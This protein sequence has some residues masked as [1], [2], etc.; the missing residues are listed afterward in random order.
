MQMWVQK[1]TDK[2]FFLTSM[3]AFLS[4]SSL[5]LHST[6]HLLLKSVS[7]SSSE[8]KVKKKQIGG[9]AKKASESRLRRHREQT[10]LT[11]NMFLKIKSW[12]ALTPEAF[13]DL[14]SN[15]SWDLAD[16]SVFG[17]TE[18]SYF[19]R[20]SFTFCLIILKWFLISLNQDRQG[21]NGHWILYPRGWNMKKL[22]KMFSP[23]VSEWQTCRGCSNISCPSS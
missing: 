12:L 23:T 1:T 4:L 9:R 7:M 16:L 13:P 2:C 6:L 18:M 8:V 21:C 3:F 11:V 17:S 14:K 19:L 5:S 20:W 10:E 15:L 22:V